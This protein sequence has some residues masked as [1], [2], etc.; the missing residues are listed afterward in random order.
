MTRTR[1]LSLLLLIISGI[2]FTFQSALGDNENA[3]T[4]ADVHKILLQA[5][6][7]QSTTPPTVAE[8]KELL[9]KALKML[10]KLPRVYHGHLAA[11]ERSVTA[12]LDELGRGDT[13]N[14]ARGEIFDAD[15]QVK[16]MM[17]K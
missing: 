2:A 14:K 1:F 7:Y 15:D 11:A 9:N 3:P 16:G 12:A 17:D 13:A 4:L 10:E 8:Q 6:G 5:A